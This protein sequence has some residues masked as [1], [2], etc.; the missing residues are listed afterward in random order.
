MIQGK[1]DGR[2]REG[3]DPEAVQGAWKEKEV[4][5]RAI[6]FVLVSET[7]GTWRITPVLRV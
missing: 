5:G 7:W 4:S 2:R 6:E 3:N 1:Q